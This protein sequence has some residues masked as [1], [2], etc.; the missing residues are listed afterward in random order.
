MISWLGKRW[1]TARSLGERLPAA[2]DVLRRW[3]PNQIEFFNRKHG[4]ALLPLCISPAMRQFPSAVLAVAP[5]LTASASTMRR[6]LRSTAAASAVL[7]RR[8]RCSSCTRH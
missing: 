4:A 3:T 5:A 8:S 6:H 7:R 2:T 1:L